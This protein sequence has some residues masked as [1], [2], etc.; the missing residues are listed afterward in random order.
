MFEV[1]RQIRIRRALA[2]VL[3][4][5]ML[6]S[7]LSAFADSPRHN[8]IAFTS[9]NG[10]FVLL[11]VYRSIER[12]PIFENGRYL[13]V[14]ET[15]R[16]EP[17]WNLFDAHGAQVLQPSN[18]LE[19]LSAG[20]APLY[21]LR[22]DIG[23]QTALISD[24]GT[25]IVVINDFSSADPVPDLDVLHFYRSGKLKA[26]YRLGELLGSVTNV[27]LT[28]SHFYW[29]FR[30]NLKFDGATLS[31]ETTECKPIVFRVDAGVRISD[32]QQASANRVDSKAECP[33]LQ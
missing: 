10:R 7:S 28:S 33:T 9:E 22:A 18:E 2:P 29:F 16:E 21:S 12:V 6:L 11:N 8:N 15:K 23:R 3:V 1:C 30:D 14:L 13:G 5:A 26:T 20:R 4:F 32:G 17:V 31:L 24:D 27:G 19:T 25:N